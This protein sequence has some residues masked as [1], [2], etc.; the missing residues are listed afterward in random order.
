MC[1]VPT[2]I[3]VTRPVLSI[4]ATAVLS[5]NQVTSLADSRFVM[6]PTNVALNTNACVAPAA[7]VGFAGVRFTDVINKSLKVEPKHPASPRSDSTG[8]ICANF[9]NL[10]IAWNSVNARR[11]KHAAPPK[12][13]AGLHSVDEV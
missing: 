9:L 11:Q 3:A 5:E 10:I 7:T 8:K 12:N 6:P 13:H 2:E 1:A 4:V